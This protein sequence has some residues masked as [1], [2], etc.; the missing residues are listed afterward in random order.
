MSGIGHNGGP[1]LGGGGFSA[2]AWR[3]ARAELVSETLPLEVIRN[4]VRRA[5]EL[6]LDYK[7]Y[8]SI[9]AATGRDVIAFLFSSNALRIGPRLVAIPGER[10]ARLDGLERVMRLAAVHRPLGPE[11]V[12][13]ANPALI[14]A[15]HAAPTLAQGWTETRAALNVMTADGRLPPDGVVVIGDT[16]LEAEWAVAGRMAG[17]LPAAR[18]FQTV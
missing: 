17:Y 5:R 9:R 2:Y 14:D 7:S 8:A 4:R 18:Y 16:M 13:H 3:R 10:A 15:A 6:G 12:L 1:G 11:A